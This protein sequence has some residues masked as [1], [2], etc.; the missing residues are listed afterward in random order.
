MTDRVQSSLSEYIPDDEVE[1]C[2]CGICGDIFATERGLSI[3]QTHTHEDTEPQECPTCGEI[4]DGTLAIKMHRTNA[5]GE[6]VSGEEF[7][8]AHCG[9][10]SRKQKYQIKNNEN[11]FCS[12]ECET[13]W[14]ESRYSGEGNPNYNRVEVTCEHCGEI[15]LVA[16]YR[17]D[18]FRF[19]SMDCK[20]NWQSENRSGAQAYAWEGG[21]ETIECEYCGDTREVYPAVEEE[22]RFCSPDCLG[23][24]RSEHQTGANNPSWSGGKE[25]VTCEH[26]DDQYQVTPAK[27]DTT[28]F[29]SQDCLDEWRSI[30]KTGQDSPRW[31]GGSK[32]RDS[33]IKQFH[34]PSWRAIREQELEEECQVCG[35]SEQL[36]LHHLIAVLDGGTNGSWNLMT[37]CRSCHGVAEAFTRQ[38]TESVLLPEKMRK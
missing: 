12:D 17:S 4:F 36:S 24:Y 28:R 30:H 29:C 22:A 23:E 18:T 6:N 13:A 10:T 5:H 7:Q 35:E 26:C 25:T 31:R 33:I 15:E 38:Y 8:C 21:M 34:G 19:C 11:N 16:P 2:Q 37:L 27:T 9:E 3:H 20:A 1:G 32:I 14:R